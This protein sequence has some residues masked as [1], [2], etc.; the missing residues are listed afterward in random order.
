M[1]C[2]TSWANCQ[3]YPCT[4]FKFSSPHAV[5]K[6]HIQKYTEQSFT[7]V[8][9]EVAKSEGHLYCFALRL[10]YEVIWII[11]ERAWHIGFEQRRAEK[12]RAMQAQMWW[13]CL[14]DR[15]KN[16]DVAIAGYLKLVPDSAQTQNQSLEMGW[17]LPITLFWQRIKI[18]NGMR[19]STPPLARVRDFEN[20]GVF[21]CVLRKGGTH[22]WEG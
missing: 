12:F 21:K 22:K 8:E 7:P 18:G 4:Y 10:P 20:S 3:N 9:I 5:A 1:S 6:I 19:A 16:L 13:T 2:P 17:E 14:F 15:K 11:F